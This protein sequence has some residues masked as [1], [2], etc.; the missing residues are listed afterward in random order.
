MTFFKILGVR[1][2]FDQLDKIFR[3]T[4]TPTEDTWP[5]VS[6]LPNYKP[7]KVKILLFQIFVIIK[8]WLNQNDH[9]T[10]QKFLS[11][12]FQ[13]CYYRPPPQRLAHVW[14]RLFDTP[15]AEGLA[16]LL[17]QQR[18]NKRIGAEQALMHRYFAD[19]PQKLHDLDDGRCSL[20]PYL[21]IV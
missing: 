3:V 20:K 10:F 18:G 6:R 8:V 15:F 21:M 9:W 11:I 13:L 12:L 4:G 19:L 2:V 5:G 1:D 7:H 16:T 14:P 17:L